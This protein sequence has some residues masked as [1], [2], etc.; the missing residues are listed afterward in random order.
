MAA[1]LRAFR[2]CDIG[3][4][5]ARLI[6]QRHVRC[7]P[8]PNVCECVCDRKWARVRACAIRY[9]NDPLDRITANYITQ[10]TATPELRNPVSTGTP[11]N[12]NQESILM[13]SIVT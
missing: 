2:G 4:P 1:L 10:D 8:V 5:P 3:L 7:L 6:V 9:A 12:A 13:K 11:H